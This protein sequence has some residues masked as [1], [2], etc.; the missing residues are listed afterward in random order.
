ME[1]KIFDKICLYISHYFNENAKYIKCY[2]FLIK[3][4]YQM[5]S[6]LYN[7]FLTT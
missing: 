4:W 3:T 1:I 6:E 7:V 5:N 2:D